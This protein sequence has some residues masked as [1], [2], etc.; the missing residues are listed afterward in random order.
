M[1]HLRTLVLSWIRQKLYFG[2]VNNECTFWPLIWM[3][4]HLYRSNGR[5]VVLVAHLFPHFSTSL[6]SRSWYMETTTL[7]L[8]YHNWKWY[9]SRMNNEHVSD[10]IWSYFRKIL[11]S[12]LFI[13]NWW[14]KLS[15]NKLNSIEDSHWSWRSQQLHL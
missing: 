12:N 1:T 14:S 7:D 13:Q 5:I 4:S 8:L 3:V 15:S 10:N 11:K 6:G 9:V 2:S